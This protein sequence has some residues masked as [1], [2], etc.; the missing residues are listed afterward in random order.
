M[1]S[2]ISIWAKQLAISVIICTIILLILPDNK[3]KKYIKVIAGIFILFCAL[4]PVT[5]KAIDLNEYNI[6]SYIKEENS[7]TKNNEYIESVNREFKAK[8]VDSIEEELKTLGFKSD[9]VSIKFDED[10]NLLQIKISK[11]KKYYQINKIEIKKDDSDRKI[12]NSEKEKIKQEIA[13]KYSIDEEKI[14]VE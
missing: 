8:M 2:N 3:N 5:S 1:I 11:V 13:K 10:Y 14:E 6:E 9:N 7:A 12:T 4:N